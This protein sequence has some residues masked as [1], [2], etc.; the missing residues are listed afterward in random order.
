MPLVL[1]VDDDR[2]SQRLL[3]GLLAPHGY[4]L[5][6]AD[7]GAQGLEMARR[8]QPDLI[9]LDV[10]MP[11]LSG[12]DVCREVRADPELAEVPVLL[13]TG[14]ED[15]DSRVR[16][17]ECGA[18]DFISKPFRAAEL[19]ARVRTITRLNRYRRIRTERARLDW[20][21]ENA[22][23]GYVLLDQ[24]G[25]TLYANRQAQTLLSLPEAL[26]LDFLDTVKSQF[27]AQPEA[28]WWES[29]P[30]FLVRPQSAS[31]P[32]VWL[33]VKAFSH[34]LGDTTERL[35]QV[36]DVSLRMATQRS[37]WSFQSMISH[38][39]RTPLTKVVWGV[40]FVLDKAGS[41]PPD[42]LREFAEMAAEG[43]SSLQTGLEEILAYTDLPRSRGTMEFRQLEPLV[44]EVV[45]LL[46][47]PPVRVEVA[48]ELTDRAFPLSRRAAE[49]VVLELCRN[50]ARFHPEHSPR[51]ELE[52]QGCDGQA[53]LEVRDDGLTLAPEQLTQA[54]LPYYQGE[55]HFT[56]NQPGMGLGLTMVG[57]LIAEVGGR[58]RLRN[59]AP[60]PGVV[61]ELRLPLA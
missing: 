26:G 27:L 30:R 35:L 14:L 41:L 43:A 51:L 47:L 9:L 15:Q 23:D 20:V 11:G 10:L 16:G 31:A 61:V 19:Q 4:T 21:I 5:A 46:E 55:A 3:E 1:I 58:C 25:R 36:R 38:K 49:L 57:S 44:N 22:Q 40:R 53:V 32:A 7:D 8:L 48:E 45:G 59:R 33:E 18:D 13:V 12:F 28:A 54:W 42:K 29:E 37:V 56:G 2:T 6:C 52:V 39:L 34:R 17:L 50:A 24:E 60:G